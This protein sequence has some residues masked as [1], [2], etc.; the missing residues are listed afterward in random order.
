DTGAPRFK[1]DGTFEG[2]IGSAIDITEEKR[3]VETL[4]ENER[5]LRVLTGKLLQAQ[6][7]ERRRI[8]RELHDD[9]NQS[10]ALLSVE[11]DRLREKT[12]ESAPEIGERIQELSAR[13][14]QL[15][16]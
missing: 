9:L 10:L 3:V 16:S 11:L 15:S 7:T 12:P 6:E 1:S 13:V 2:Y 4:R 14:K 8:A 5:E